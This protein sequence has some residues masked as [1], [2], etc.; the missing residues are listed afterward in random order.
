MK[1]IRFIVSR[2][3][4]ICNARRSITT[5]SAPVTSL[6]DTHKTFLDLVKHQGSS[7]SITYSRIGSNV[8]QMLI[9]NY[10]KKN[11]ITGKMMHDLCGIVDDN[12]KNDD[13]SVLIITGVKDMFCSGADLDLIRTVLVDSEKA[14]L[15]SLF[16]TDALNRIRDANMISVCLMNG[17]AVGG[18][19][20][21][22]T[23]GDY[24]VLAVDDADDTFIQFIHAK[25]GSVTGWG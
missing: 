25:L 16:M 17:K 21:F 10:D 13:G 14:K 23:V 8:S 7:G 18:G 3:R 1:T 15:M 22:S 24:R 6:Y 5:S 2:C 11:A 4:G 9:S 20:E 19:A 12:I